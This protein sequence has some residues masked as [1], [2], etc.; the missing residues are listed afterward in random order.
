MPLHKKIIKLNY[1]DIWS[2]RITDEFSIKMKIVF[3]LGPTSTE[4][5]IW[6]EHR[7]AVAICDVIKAVVEAVKAVVIDSFS[8]IGD[9]LFFGDKSFELRP[10]SINTYE[11]N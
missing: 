4:Q 10:P 8:P 1:R 5:K 9:V 11:N 3:V 7:E 2:W 6:Q